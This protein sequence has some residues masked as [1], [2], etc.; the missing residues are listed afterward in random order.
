[1]TQTRQARDVTRQAAREAD[2]VER[3]A[4]RVG[5]GVAV[6]L[7]ECLHD[8][9]ISE[10]NTERHLDEFETEDAIL[11]A[12]K[13]EAERDDWI[14]R[15][16]EVIDERAA[17]LGACY[18]FSIDGNNITYRGSRTFTYEFCLAACYVPNI[19]LRRY[20][21]IQ[22]A[23]ERLAG[24]ALGLLLGK[25]SS[26]LRTGYPPDEGLGSF[27]Q[28]ISRLDQLMPDEWAI[29]PNTRIENPQDGGV[30]SVV[31][32]KPDSRSGSL[33]FVGNCTCGR[34][35]LK[36]KKH[37]ELAS[38]L[39]DP[40]LSRPK[41]KQL[42]DFF[43]LPFHVYESRDWYE[44]CLAGRFALDRLRLVQLAEKSSPVEWKALTQDYSLDLLD[45]IATAEPE[46]QPL[47]AA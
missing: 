34:N 22:K 26:S 31:W 24:L 45:L 27:D 3:A 19:S 47:L 8:N 25:N 35:W 29:D 14:A 41:C 36:E 21:P 7:E 4:L 1:M 20:K 42:N 30:D 28:I 2:D 11:R 40:I 9:D 32:L 33:I 6:P 13:E 43:A 15:V 23:F 37:T 39:L 46:L 5:R 12:A 16:G 18:P 44:V 17:I 10:D 38:D